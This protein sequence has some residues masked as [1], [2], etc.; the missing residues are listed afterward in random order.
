MIL[1]L[2]VG[3][4]VSGWPGH[5]AAD[6]IQDSIKAEFVDR[7][8]RLIN[9]P[10]SSSVADP[11]KPFVIGVIGNSSIRTAFTSMAES[12]RI[13]GK[14]TV[15]RHFQSASQVGDCQIL[16][17]SGSSS[18][19]LEG[20]LQSVR[21]KPILTIG[22]T[23][24]FARRGVMINFKLAGDYIRFEIN[25]RSADRAGLIMTDALLGLG[26]VVS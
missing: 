20:I 22:D 5:G 15:V 1:I 26:D 6:A 3:A 2:A 4:V 23:V 8:S 17:I 10:A 18:G 19:E 14:T 21:G 12:A 24:G 11:A 13:K 16:F 9:W 7:F 25:K